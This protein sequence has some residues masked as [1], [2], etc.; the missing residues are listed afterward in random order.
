MTTPS[1]ASTPYFLDSEMWLNSHCGQA[2]V[3][4][5]LTIGYL[6]DV[7][8][9]AYGSFWAEKTAGGVY[10]Y[11][12]ISTFTP[13]PSVTDQYQIS[14]SPTTNVWNIY[15]DGSL[16]TSDNVGFWAGS[17]VQMGGEIWSSAGHADTF[18]MYGKV[19][20][21]AG[22]IVNWGTPQLASITDPTKTNGI[23]YSDSEWSWN[24]TS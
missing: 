18:T 22:S 4:E 11:V 3:E 7:G 9:G 19:V 10:R 1:S 15:F 14:R 13:N 16:R 8:T 2:W 23:S 17:C 5:G 21:S 6:S 12:T 24:T 20:N